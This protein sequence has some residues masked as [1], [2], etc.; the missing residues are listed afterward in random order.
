MIPTIDTTETDTATIDLKL[1]DDSQAVYRAALVQ[2]VR[3]WKEE[4]A[5]T[6]IQYAVHKALGNAEQVEALQKYLVQ[7]ATALKL[8]RGKVD[9][10]NKSG[11]RSA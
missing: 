7:C 1:F 10:F 6:M 5:R 3:A 4:E 9:E 11:E 8:L 2:Q